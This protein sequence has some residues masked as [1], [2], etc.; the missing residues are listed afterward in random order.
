VDFTDG[1]VAEAKTCSSC[2]AA[3]YQ[4]LV[5]ADVGPALGIRVVNTLQQNPSIDAV[6]AGYD[7]AAR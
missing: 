7:A 4:Y 1:M 3:P 5:A 2:K 6:S